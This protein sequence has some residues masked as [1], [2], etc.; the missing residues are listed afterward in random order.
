ALVVHVA[1]ATPEGEAL[2]PEKL[3]PI[4]RMVAA[5]AMCLVAR[6]AQQA[7][8]VFREKSI[9]VLELITERRF[10]PTTLSKFSLILE[11]G[12]VQVL[13]V[14]EWAINEEV[15]AIAIADGID[16]EAAMV[17]V[18]AAQP[19]LPARAARQVEVGAA[20]QY[21]AAGSLIHVRRKQRGSVEVPLAL[22]AG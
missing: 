4:D 15:E 17:V 19:M 13:L 11:A 8:E 7:G 3:L 22:H 20:Q 2:V 9:F 5:Q 14:R 18:I 10:G 6:V 1:Q 21:V 16:P 12:A